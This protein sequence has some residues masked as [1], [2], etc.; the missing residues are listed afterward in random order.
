MPKAI[1]KTP[2]IL[3]VVETE[4][5]PKSRFLF[6]AFRM[7]LAGLL[8]RQKCLNLRASWGEVQNFE[9]GPTGIFWKYLIITQ[10]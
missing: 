10:Y 3:L 2:N 1:A 9:S 6:W 4:T 7:G 8:G 5:P